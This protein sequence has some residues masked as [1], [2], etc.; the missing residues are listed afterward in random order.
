[1]EHHDYFYRHWKIAHKF[2]PHLL[3][4]NNH[5]VLIQLA[6]EFRGRDAPEKPCDGIDRSLL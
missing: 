6:I 1:M 5:F 4:L 3:S 2:P